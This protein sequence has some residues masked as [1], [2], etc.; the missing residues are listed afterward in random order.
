MFERFRRWARRRPG[1]AA[2]VFER[3]LAEVIGSLTDPF[4]MFDRRFRF[5]FVNDVAVTVLRKSREELIGSDVRE[6]FP[7]A[8][9]LQ[10]AMKD[11][12]PVEFESF[13]QPFQRWHFA[14]AYPTSDG[15]LALFFRDITDRKAE[16]E[17]ASAFKDEFLSTLAHEL[18][19]PTNAILGWVRVLERR[20]DDTSLAHEGIQVI[21]RNA[22]AQSD[23][24]AD[25]LDMSRII[26]GKIRLEV[27]TV[28]LSH[29]IA[30][31]VA[32]MRPAA[33]A[34]QIR[35]DLLLDPSA[36]TIRGDAGRI[37]QVVTNLLSNAVKFT[38]KDGRIEIA[39]S[40]SGSQSEIAVRDTGVGIAPA[41]LP[42]V[43]DR[44]RQCDA[45]TTREQG[46]LGLGLAIVKQLVELHGGT[47]RV[48]SP[49]TGH[50]TTFTVALPV[51]LLH[52]VDDDA[53]PELLST[54]A[55]FARGAK[56]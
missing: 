32:T 55:V 36:D 33:E 40:K 45:S 4:V 34:K 3:R 20:P 38:P 16:A 27:A 26:S 2:G 13:H 47:V 8:E 7:Q 43:F 50:G 30:A 35:I 41:F 31:A 52:A 37:Q 25:L 14:K 42:Y 5:V 12:V 9:Q 22:K 18:R 6:A 1:R 10:R 24:I 19:T 54:L 21:A 11:R 39:L 49:G 28:D 23:L 51:A 44:F 17:R 46:G 48:D 56:H 15:G 53:A 29:V